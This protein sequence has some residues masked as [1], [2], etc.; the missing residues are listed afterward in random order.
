MPDPPGE[1]PSDPR[2]PPGWYPNPDGG[3]LERWWDGEAWDEPLLTPEEKKAQARNRRLAKA[4]GPNEAKP[5]GLGKAK[6]D[7]AKAAGHERAKAD[8]PLWVSW[9]FIIAVLLMIGLFIFDA[10]TS[11]ETGSLWERLSRGPET[12]MRQRP[13]GKWEPAN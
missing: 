9:L 8:P 7:G 13:D 5:G 2:R 12:L 3:R 11:N 10:G 4:D 6:A 1:R